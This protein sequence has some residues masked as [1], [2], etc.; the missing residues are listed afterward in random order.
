M[1]N[2]K[3]ISGCS[4]PSPRLYDSRTGEPID[5]FNGYAEY[6]FDHIV[7]RTANN[8]NQAYTCRVAKLLDFLIEIGILDDQ[9]Q[10]DYASTVAN[11]PLYRKYLT[12][13]TNSKDPI[14]QELA[15]RL[16]RTAIEGESA[17][18]HLA[19]AKDFLSY[20]QLKQL[21]QWELE[22]RINPGTPKPPSFIETKRVPPSRAEAES[23]ARNSIIGAHTGVI[24][25]TRTRALV[26][27]SKKRKKIRIKD[28]PA[29]HIL[30]LIHHIP[31]PLY[32]C[33]A[34]LMAGGG[35]RES[36]AIAVERSNIVFDKKT[37][38]ATVTLNVGEI[39]IESPDAL[40]DMSG[41]KG[42]KTN[43]VFM[44]EPLKTIFLKNYAEYL[45]IRPLSE[46]KYAFL[47][48]S[49]NSYG[50]SLFEEIKQNTIN[51]TIN[52][53]LA[54]AQKKIIALNG[55]KAFTCHSLRHFYGMWL[56][57]CIYIPGRPWIGLET[58]EIQ[59]LMGHANEATTEIYS[60]ISPERLHLEIEAADKALILLLPNHSMAEYKGL[61]YSEL[62]EYH[63]N[64]SKAQ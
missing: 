26:S 51:K 14:I 4:L 30:E 29:A 63:F 43:K 5:L 48:E 47:S 18:G 49:K 25:V 31:H 28:F 32:R 38:T 58:K 61:I 36:E 24:K 8:T 3:L 7:H 19:A 27:T 55:N 40:P 64:Q 12:E 20:L 2:V 21:E 23:I 59:I 35:L 15:N 10:F 62:A 53:V 60:R 22:K 52:R 17:D 16:E 56:R 6:R 33:L 9:K 46:S 11:L 57:N 44:V 45:A 41:S 34:L 37:M 42:R 54:K 39:D 50:K 13:G 1:K